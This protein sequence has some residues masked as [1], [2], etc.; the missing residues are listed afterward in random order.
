MKLNANDIPIFAVVAEKSG[1]TAAANVLGIPKSTVSNALNRLETA[2]GVRLLERN[3]RNI[4]LTSEGEHFYKHS[5][6]ITE[7]LEQAEAEMNGL[8]HEP[9]GNLSVAL[10][11][12]FSREV[13]KG[14]LKEFME[15]YPSIH[16]DIHVSNDYKV[17]VISDRF[18]I[19]IKIG[20]L[21]DSELIVS[22]LLHTSLVWVAS[23]HYLSSTG[24]D[25]N[26]NQLSEHVKI[27][28]KR[29]TKLGITM[30]KG[31]IKKSIQLDNVSVSNDPLMVR[32]M[33][34]AGDGI[35]LTPLL[36]CKDQLESGELIQLAPD[37][38][39]EP[40]SIVSAVYPSRRL[41]SA[42]TVLFIDFLKEIIA[43]K[44]A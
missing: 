33:L 19:A 7:K 40:E 42:K 10:T 37:W 23:P 27:I 14:H 11:M 16:L 25:G 2:L 15:R 13:M 41:V 39:V 28:D 9:K 30:K 18:D 26:E 34:I 4:R 43:R 20:E 12:A 1:I 17:D 31:R 36:F 29:Y 44:H 22:K 24:F 3:S 21:P 35:S 38:K 8:Q 5:Q 6:I 32:D